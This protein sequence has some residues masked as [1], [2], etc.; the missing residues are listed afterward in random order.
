MRLAGVPHLGRMPMAGPWGRA[1]WGGRARLTPARSA[2]LALVVVVSLLAACGGTTRTNALRT[3]AV[4]SVTASGRATATAVSFPTPVTPPY[5]FP[6]AWQAPASAPTQVDPYQ[7]LV[8]APSSP[9][10]GYACDVAPEPGQTGAGPFFTT[11]DGGQTWHVTGRPPFGDNVGNCSVFVDA[12]NAQDVFVKQDI[13]HPENPVA[14][15]TFWRSQDGGASWHQLATVPLLTQGPTDVQDLGVLGQRIVIT[16]SLQAEGQLDNDLYASDDGGATWHQ[17]AT[18]LPARVY[19]FAIV[20]ASII[21]QTIAPVA[22]S[23]ERRHAAAPASVPVAM[24]GTS[25]RSMPATRP[26]SSQG[27]PPVYYLSTDA[28][29]TWSKLNVPAGQAV[30]VPAASGAG[31]YGVSV[32]QPTA[33]GAPVIAY[34]SA[35][36]AATWQAL[37][38]LVGVEGGWLDPG[39]LGLDLVVAPDGSVLTYTQ[40]LVGQQAGESD[41]GLFALRMGGGTPAWQPLAPMTDNVMRVAL[42][43]SGVRVWTVRGAQGGIPGPGTPVYVDLA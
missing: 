9:Q 14:A 7:G 26:G 38:T 15:P 29:T 12:A 31:F 21:V 17:F 35:D 6:L 42:T 39:S 30:F 20:G 28:G 4:P 40:H 24:P 33:Y 11:Q 18:A 5:S 3:R 23:T 2:A 36:N 34:W 32:A 8:F 10:V 22:S 41:A 16:L 13:S 43:A 1:E 19:G 37:P 25:P 27:P